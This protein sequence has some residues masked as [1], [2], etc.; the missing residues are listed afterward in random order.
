MDFNSFNIVDFS[1][2]AILAISGIFA[3]LRGFIRELLGL[4]GWGIAFVVARLASPLVATQLNGF[5]DNE[6]ILDSVSWII[7]FIITII[8]WFII[9][10]II[11]SQIKQIFPAGLDRIF[12][13]A[14]GVLRGFLMVTIVYMGVLFAIK[15]EAALPEAFLQSASI[16]P[17]RAMAA[18]ASGLVPEKL[19]SN[20]TDKIP[21]QEIIKDAEELLPNA[22]NP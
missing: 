7:P 1:V 5:L 10:N 3:T 2:L 17:V 4:M 6:A 13:F 16:T 19:L 20:I 14:F 18:A 21:P 12:G 8:I 15:D 22:T 9:A 11:A